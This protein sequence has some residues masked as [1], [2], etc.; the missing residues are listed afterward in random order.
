MFLKRHP[1]K[2]IPVGEK[3]IGNINKNLNVHEYVCFS[4]WRNGGNDIRYCRLKDTVI[5]I[6][7]LATDLRF[8]TS[9]SCKSVYYLGEEIT[10]DFKKLVLVVI[11]L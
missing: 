7:P 4:I 2:F 10:S 8:R 6:P 9:H 1:I 3:P 5:P 11:S